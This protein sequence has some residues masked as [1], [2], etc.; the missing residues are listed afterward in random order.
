MHQTTLRTLC[1]INLFLEITGIRPDGYHELVTL[2]YPVAEPHDLL[3]IT[4]ADEGTGLTLT[5]SQPELA[6]PDNLVARAYRAYAEKTGFAPGLSVH[7]TKGV[8]SGAGLG[9]G[10]ADAAAMLGYCNGQPHEK[11]L[12]PDDLCALAATLG[13]DVPFFLGAGPAWATGIGDSLRPAPQSL[14]GLHI[15]LAVPTGRVVTAW[16]YRQWDIRQA[17]QTIS[18]PGLTIAEGAATRPFCV[19]G[20][21]IANCFE[22]VVFPA[23]PEVRA[24]KERLLASGAAAAAMSGSGSAVFGL[25]REAPDAAQAAETLLAEGLEAWTTR[26]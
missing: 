14:A 1:K 17:G 12:S 16:A 4:P 22:A 18:T 8:P 25:F 20:M 6:G 5:C 2:F 24:L 11:A 7:L 9:G 13:A 23:H 26:L 21:V 19:S 3:E 15:V 10:S